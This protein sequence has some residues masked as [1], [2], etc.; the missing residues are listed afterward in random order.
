[1]FY[2]SYLA[3]VKEP[4]FGSQWVYDEN[5]GWIWDIALGGRVGILRHGNT[6]LMNPHGWQLDME[7]AALPR[8]DF[9]DD[10]ELAACD[11]RFGIPVTYAR[12]PH[13]FKT[14]YYHLSSHLGDE[15]MLRH[16][17]VP[18]FNFCRDAIMFGYSYY[19]NDDLR[20][21]AEID[22]ALSNDAQAEPLELLFGVDYAP[23]MPTGTHPKPFI[24]INGHLRE[25]VDYG[26]NVT[27]Q[28][29]LAWRGKSGHLFRVGM[30]CYV[31]MSDQYE[32]YDQY[33]SKVGIGVWYDY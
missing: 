2:K 4:R 8:L 24:A 11:Y 19:L 17:D 23:G 6:D 28:S 31:G 13:R 18:R 1:L 21:Y 16:Q 29:G 14:G 15:L 32:F 33:E 20:L 26:G 27:V 7:G 30:H 9:G 3:G 25:E 10:T 22:Y 5:L 12:G